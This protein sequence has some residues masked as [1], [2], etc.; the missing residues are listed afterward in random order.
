MSKLHETLG[1]KT[2][3]VHAGE[4]KVLGNP[5]EPLSDTARQDLQS[6]VDSYYN[7]F[8]DAV[9]AGRGTTATRVRKDMGGGKMLLPEEAKAAGMIDRVGTLAKLLDSM[10]ANESGVRAEIGSGT[11]TAQGAAARLRVL[12]V[13]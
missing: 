11:V 9:A 13:A 5:F 4:N 10:G 1:V 3:L 12:E 7:S 6:K 2:T 8:V